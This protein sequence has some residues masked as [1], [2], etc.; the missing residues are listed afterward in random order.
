MLADYTDLVAG[1]IQGENGNCPDVESSARL[2]LLR[3]LPMRFSLV[4]LTLALVALPTLAQAEG[5]K[6]PAK[7]PQVARLLD[8]KKTLNWNHT[9]GG[10]K[11]RYGHA[12]ALVEATADKLA[13][14]AVEFGKYKELHRKF[15]TARVIGKEGDQTDVYMRYPVTIGPVTIELYEVMRFSP[16]RANAGT[17]RHRGARHQRRHEAWPHASSPSSPWTRST[18]SSR[19][20]SC[21]FPSCRRRSRTSTRSSATARRTS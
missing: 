2:V 1:R 9:L 3:N 15:A 6:E 10:G 19:S 5:E 18:R 13:K 17:P 16:D 8:A 21:S 11:D 20:T 12:E 4:V 14:T 7:D